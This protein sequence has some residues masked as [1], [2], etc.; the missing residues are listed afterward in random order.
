MNNWIEP[1]IQLMIFFLK[2]HVVGIEDEDFFQISTP[3][4]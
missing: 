1:D 2:F 3:N 4:Q